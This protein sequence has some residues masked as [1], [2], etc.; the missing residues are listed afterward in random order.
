MQRVAAP[1][2]VRR[3]VRFSAGDPDVT[4]VEF[5]G[6]G[7]PTIVDYARRVERRKQRVAPPPCD[8]A[9]RK[10]IAR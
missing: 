4:E 3:A 10:E 7:L 8:E 9:L 6:K 1:A 2:P 5:V